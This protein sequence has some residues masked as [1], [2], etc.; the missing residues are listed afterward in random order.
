[1]DVKD[2]WQLT[3]IGEL[4]DQGGGSVQTGPFGSQLH[5]SDYVEHGIPV[6]MPVNLGDNRIIEHAIARVSVATQ[7]R[8]TR[9]LL[10]ERDIVYGRRGDIGRRALVRRHESGWLCGTGCLRIRFGNAPVD[11]RFVS[12][13]L[14]QQHVKELILAKAVGSTMPN[15]N[16][17]ILRSGSYLPPSSPYPAPYWG[18]FRGAG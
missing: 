14:G 12:Y 17:E 18:D 4:C 2:G 9:H 15:L 11:S 1:V 8:L 7:A 10:Q 5:A 16:T 3:T 6:I 13:F